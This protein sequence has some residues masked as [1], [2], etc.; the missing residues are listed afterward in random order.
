[1]SAIAGAAAKRHDKQI[2]IYKFF[3]KNLLNKTSSHYLRDF[4][5]VLDNKSFLW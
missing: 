1:M 5:K 2:T 3:T 4:P